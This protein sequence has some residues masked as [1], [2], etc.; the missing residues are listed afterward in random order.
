MM[1]AQTE[2]LPNRAPRWR[3]FW[4]MF[5]LIVAG[6]AIFALPFHLARFFRPT[7]LEVFDLSNTELGAAQGVYGVFA[8][9]SYFVGGPIA[10]RFPAR[11]LLAGSLWSTACGGIY[12]AT[13]PGYRGAAVLWGVFGVTTI[14]LFWAAL[15]RATRDWGGDDRQGRAY[16]LLDGG[17]GLLAAVFASLAVAIFGWVFPEQ[18]ANA[19]LLEKREALRLVIFAYTALTVAAGALAWFSIVERHRDT[20]IEPTPFAATTLPAMLHVLRMPAVWLQAVIVVCAYVG[21]KGFDNYSLFS[22]EAYGVNEVEA[23]SIVAIA[24]WMR[25]IA[26]L[27]AGLLGDRF[28]IARM[29]VAGF[30]LLLGSQLYFALTTPGPSWLLLSNTLITCTA[31]FALRGLYFALFEEAKVP[32][33]VTGTA[34]GIVSVV[35]FTPDIF[36]AL[37]GGILLDRSPGLAGHQHY[38]LFLAV[39]AFLGLL[40]SFALLRHLKPQPVTTH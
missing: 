3:R 6:E 8:M 32:M 22:V 25:P 13:F 35:G 40:A 33:A 18:Q 26:A 37:I 19:T 29:T 15:I 28:G 36:V 24:S 5:G 14:L 30:L 16:G 34:I 12:M 31:I 38:F 9:L 39:F 23:A 10:D 27:G 2:S 11:K 20:S 4:T 7:V 1:V 17:R 21:Y